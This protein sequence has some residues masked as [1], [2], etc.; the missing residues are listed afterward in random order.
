MI[1]VLIQQYEKIA[2]IEK[3]N[4]YTTVLDISLI[5]Q[6]LVEVCPFDLSFLSILLKHLAIATPLKLLNKNM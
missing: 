6:I 1:A 5:S 3:Q 2:A 4:N